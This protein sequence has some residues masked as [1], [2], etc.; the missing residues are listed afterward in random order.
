M[1]KSEETTSPNR[2]LLEVR[3]VCKRFGGLR[4]LD[5]VNCRVSEGQ[6]GAIIGPNGAGKTTLF[7]CLTGVDRPTS[8]SIRFLDREIGGMAPH[9][10]AATG[11]AR[12]W[13]TIRLFE[14]MSVLEN[15]LVGGHCTGRCGMLGAALRLPGHY[16]EER[17]MRLAAM[18][19][20]DSLGIADLAPR[21]VGALPFLQQRRV[22]LA[23]AL[24]S[25]PRLLLLDEPAAGLNSRETTALGDLI[26]KIRDLGV[27]V[28]LVEHDM[29]LV[30]EIS[31]NVLVLDH[32]TPIAEGTPREIQNDPQVIAVYLGMEA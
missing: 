14:H 17:R 21:S 23:R 25:Q 7:N 9:R 11:I 19:C 1:T 20:L 29:S 10:I 6:V 5:D 13:Q 22:E 4:A 32:G 8:G 15:V 24:V 3:N 18:E 12:T 2:C 16:R 30:M 31:E 27:T 26:L 28:V